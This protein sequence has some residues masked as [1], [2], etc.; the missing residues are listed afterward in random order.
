MTESARQLPPREI[1]LIKPGSLGDVVHALP[2]AHALK[3]AFANAR[4]TWVIDPRWAPL[5]CNNPAVDAILEFPRTQFRG[6]SGW[7]RGAAWFAGLRGRKPDLT[8]DLQ[9]LLRS[10]MIARAAG[11]RRVIG[12]SDAREG[13]RFFCNATADVSGVSHAVDR[14]L[15]VLPLCGVPIPAHPEFPIPAATPP[16]GLPLRFTAIHPFARGA[17]KS[18][19]DD[20]IRF[21]CDA[22]KPSPVVL[23]GMGTPPANLP[24]HVMNLTH[25]T[26]LLEMVGLLRTS[27][28]V[29]SVDSGPMHVACALKRPLLAIHTWSDPRRVGPYSADAWILQGGVLRR[30]ELGAK[31]PLQPAAPMNQNLLGQAADWARKILQS[32]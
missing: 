4:L 6:P 3:T 13:G 30:Q 28:A 10:G 15:Q 20:S 14:Y 5:V 17:G 8:V 26:T 32:D 16:P 2:V 31:T 27:T 7:V 12:L 22:L 1:L 29:I 21:L 24:G 19:D 11:S 18:L 25:A 23:C 9:G